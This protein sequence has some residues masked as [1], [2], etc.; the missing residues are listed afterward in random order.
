MVVRLA[1]GG[2]RRGFIF[3][4]VIPPPEPDHR[5][6]EQPPFSSPTPLSL[7]EMEAFLCAIYDGVKAGDT[8][9]DEE[10]LSLDW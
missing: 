1:Y 8:I 10:E 4:V 5:G 6:G 7:D 9:E 3:R 2:E